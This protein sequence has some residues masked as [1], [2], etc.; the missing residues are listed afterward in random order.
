ML[1]LEDKLLNVLYAIPFI[2][3]C[4]LYALRVAGK[5][6]EKERGEDE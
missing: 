3:I 6:L 5:E 2:A 1:T 4:L